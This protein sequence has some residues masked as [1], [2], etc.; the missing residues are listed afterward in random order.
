M[1]IE[2]LK[3]DLSDAAQEKIKGVIEQA[4]DKKVHKEIK[5]LSR[6]ITVKLILTGVFV[7]GTI[8]LINNADT[9]VK[10]LE[11]PKND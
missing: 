2:D 11:Q 1:I 10:Y 3:A 6:K 4:V 8:L 5:K 7:A 9:I